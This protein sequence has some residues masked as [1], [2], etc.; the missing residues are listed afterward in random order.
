MQTH[1]FPRPEGGSDDKSARV[2]ARTLLVVDDQEVNRKILARHLELLGY[3]VIT[4]S[5]GR[6]AL[7]L[8]RKHD[9]DGVVLDVVMEGMDGLEVCRRLKADPATWLIPVVMVTVLNN[10]ADRIRA[11]EAGADE[12]LSKPVYPEELSARMRSLMRWREAREALEQARLD[13]MRALFGRYLCPEL[14]ED[15][16]ASAEGRP[17]DLLAR[18]QRRDAVVM[19]AD[20]RGFTGLAERLEADT[21]VELLN[22]YF[23]M[24]TGVAHAHKGTVFSMAGDALLV[25]FGVP[26]TQADA[27][28][29]AFD[30]ARE[31]QRAFGEL[32]TRWQD[33]WQVDSG[34]GIGLNR[35]E[36]VVGNVGSEAFMSYTVVGDA[37]NVADRLQKQADAGEILLSGRVHEGLSPDRAK[38]CERMAN[39]LFLKG[40]TRPLPVLRWSERDD[41]GR[42]R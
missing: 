14:V 25:G 28:D 12:F 39:P 10:Q 36:V 24:A 23:A 42:E 41:A 29:R 21:A 16:L 7:E 5:T 35:G 18:S 11:M 40:R 8:V 37:V 4:A 6:G 20:L 1:G 38:T 9:V 27:A 15:L 17:E 3:R 33:R 31:M 13:Q 34:L 2:P 19:F 32:R 30:C 22:D 26:L